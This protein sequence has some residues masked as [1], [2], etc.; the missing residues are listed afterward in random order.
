MNKATL[1]ISGT[2]G[3]KA[4][5]KSVDPLATCVGDERAKVRVSLE[6]RLSRVGTYS[7]VALHCEVELVCG[8]T[9]PAVEAAKALALAECMVF[10]DSNIE[11]ALA[12]LDAH[13]AKL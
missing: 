13:V 9:K 8:Q 2:Q 12:L 4:M 6:E 3:T 11:D 1:T 5:T 7:S 10:I